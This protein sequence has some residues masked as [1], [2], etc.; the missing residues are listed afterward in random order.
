MHFKT[1]TWAP[2]DMEAIDEK[3]LT[4][5]TVEVVIQVNGKLRSKLTL[6]LDEL[7]D[8]ERIIEMALADEKIQKFTENGVKK[9]IFV[10][11]AK[12]VNIVA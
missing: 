11:K 10:K 2:I 3:Y 7:E 1:L 8:E 12:L 4:E 6:G 9:T 5:D